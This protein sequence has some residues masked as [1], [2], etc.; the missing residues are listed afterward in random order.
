MP[1][2]GAESA[3]ASVETV[4]TRLMAAAV[5][6]NER[7][8]IGSSGCGAK[9]VVKA[10]KPANTTAAVRVLD[11][12]FPC[13]ETGSGADRAMASIMRWARSTL[14]TLAHTNEH[15]GWA[16]LFLGYRDELGK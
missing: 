13:P 4:I 15:G 1:A 12:R 2:S 5:T 9:S 8:S 6:P 14:L 3:T 16:V 11:C 7:A 10:Q